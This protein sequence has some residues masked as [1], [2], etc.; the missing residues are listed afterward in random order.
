MTLLPKRAR[1][2]GQLI[3]ISA[4]DIPT[5]NKIPV[6]GELMT[7]KAEGLALDV[8]SGTGYTTSYVS[9]CRREADGAGMYL[10]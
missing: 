10:L 2:F 7:A 9:G 8:G 3:A 4:Y 5:R 6:I 1:A